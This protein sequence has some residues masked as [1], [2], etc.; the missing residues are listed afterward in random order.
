MKEVTIYY[1]QM[2]NP[3]ELSPVAVLPELEIRE[4]VRPQFK[5]N[6]FLYQLVGEPWSWTDKLS[7]SDDQ[8]RELV[9]SADHR[10]WVA[11]YQGAIA[12]YY[13]LHRNGGDVE[14][15]YFGLVSDCIGMGFGAA[16]LSN[17]IESAWQWQGASRVWVHTCS[18]DH[19]AALKNYQARGLTLYR[20]EVEQQ[21]PA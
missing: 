19:P 3:Q 20:E 7:W 16:L 12:G 4:C 5:F 9:E 14:I 2:N 1:L 8:W 13:E 21:V 6:R 10:T 11:Y 15:L 17:A 18:L